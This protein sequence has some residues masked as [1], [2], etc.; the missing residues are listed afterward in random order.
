MGGGEPNFL[1]VCEKLDRRHSDGR[2][3]VSDRINLFIEVESDLSTFVQPGAI[4]RGY[5]KLLYVS[6]VS[7]SE[8]RR[9][10]KEFPLCVGSGGKATGRSQKLRFVTV[11]FP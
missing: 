6:I 1:A 5:W 9:S 11:L 8:V 10:S 2:T 4:A 7:T 3:D